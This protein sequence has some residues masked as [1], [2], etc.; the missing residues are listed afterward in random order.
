MTSTKNLSIAD[1]TKNSA[2]SKSQNNS[3]SSLKDEQN[4]RSNLHRVR[5][6]N[7]QESFFD[8]SILTQ[9]EISLN[10]L[11]HRPKKKKKGS[12]FL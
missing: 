10:C 3:K 1:V 11:Y 12:I 2:N 6:D 7:P 9:S 4:L 8:R 5:I